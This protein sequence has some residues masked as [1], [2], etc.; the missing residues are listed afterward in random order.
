MDID[1]DLGH[2]GLSLQ[3]SACASCSP[4]T[5]RCWATPCRRVLD[6]VTNGIITA[7]NATEKVTSPLDSTVGKLD[8]IVKA[9]IHV[10]AAQNPTQGNSCNEGVQF[11][12]D[13]AQQ[14]GRASCRE[15]VYSSV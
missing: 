1:T 9:M 6:C 5:T 10:A 7:K 15:R 14:I 4:K 13:A 3:K 11:L 2:S 12:A 8:V